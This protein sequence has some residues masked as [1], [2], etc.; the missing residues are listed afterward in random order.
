M[1]KTNKRTLLLTS[2]I[3]VLPL[4]IG[5]V[6]W[7]QLPNTM[8]THFGIHGDADGFSSKPF[9][10]LF[11]PLFILAIHWFSVFIISADPRK[12]NISPK[13]FT[14]ILWILPILSLYT[15]LLIYSYNMGY[16]LHVKTW[17]EGFLGFLFLI[18]GN[19]LPKTRQNYT[20]G[21]KVPWT[22]DNVENWNRTHRLAGY[23]WILCGLIIVVQSFL[24]L[25]NVYLMIGLIL[26]MTLIPCIYSYWLHIHDH[27]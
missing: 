13:I 16:P 12:Q 5:L 6:L 10:I 19:Y 18:I 15:G 2:L 22:L 4:C 21:I 23:V 3:I 14:I 7:N 8:A 17:T 26:L 25:H 9:A 24:G 20:I 27:L 1:I 11:V